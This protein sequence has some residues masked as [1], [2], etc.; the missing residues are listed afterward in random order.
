MT[1]TTTEITLARG[2]HAGP[3]KGGCLLEWAALF[4]DE[5][6]SDH[7]DSVSPVIGAFGRRW[8]DDLDDDDRQRLLRFIPKP[9]RYGPV[10]DGGWGSGPLITGT[11]TGAADDERRAWMATDWMVRTYLPAWLRLAKLEDQAV[12]VESLPELVD[13][14]RWRSSESI[15]IGVRKDAY[16]AGA[17]ARDAAR[18][19]L[20]LTVMSL[21]ESATD[22]L[23]RMIAVESM[24]S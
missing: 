21:Q 20:R 22:L 11:N 5:A 8:N 14:G 1:E 18:D 19:A 16:A 4:A 6:W 10:E 3:E 24:A 2:N 23:C 17:A 9:E 12:A 7:P 13:A 15:V